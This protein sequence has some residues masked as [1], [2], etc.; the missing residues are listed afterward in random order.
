MLEVSGETFDQK[1]GWLNQ[2]PV[3]LTQGLINV[4]LCENMRLVGQE[5][6][7]MVLD[8]EWR[9]LDIFKNETVL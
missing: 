3:N 8:L 7:N 9:L 6:L 5:L 4:S 1:A 2:S